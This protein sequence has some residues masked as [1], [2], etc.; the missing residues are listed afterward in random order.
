MSERAP[1]PICD[2]FQGKKWGEEGTCSFYSEAPNSSCTPADQE[3][4]TLCVATSDYMGP[5]HAVDISNVKRVEEREEVLAQSSC[6]KVTW[7]AGPNRQQPPPNS[8]NIPIS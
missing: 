1:A 7:K 8:A 4:F 3:S 5:L 6:Q 2:R